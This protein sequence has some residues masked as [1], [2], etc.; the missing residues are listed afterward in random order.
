MCACVFCFTISNH[1]FGMCMRINQKGKSNFFHVVFS[2]KTQTLFSTA[3]SCVFFF[4]VFSSSSLSF[5]LFYFTFLKFTSQNKRKK[6]TEQKMNTFFF[7][8]FVVTRATQLLTTI[9]S[10]FNLK[11]LLNSVF[12]SRRFA[13]S[14]AWLVG[15]LF[16]F[17]YTLSLK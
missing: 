7:C 5:F 4:L 14:F 11:F 15:C 10:F 17:P 16:V 8:V 13:T 1:P 6:Q 9:F 3:F 12:F 2:H